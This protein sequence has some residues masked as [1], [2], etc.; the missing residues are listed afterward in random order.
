MTS[1]SKLDLYR[2]FKTNLAT[3]DYLRG[4]LSQSKQYLIRLRTGSSCL[5]VETGRWEVFKVDGKRVKLERK[6]RKC[7]LCFKD[8]EDEK[9]VICDC[10]VFKEERNEIL[11]EFFS[12]NKPK[13][14]S[15]LELIAGHGQDKLINFLEKAM[16]KRKRLLRFCNS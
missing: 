10:P 13:I 12:E 5:R 16:P 2:Q 6:F 1:N 14:D 7:K 4:D 8:V 9:H 11:G 15:L 3:E